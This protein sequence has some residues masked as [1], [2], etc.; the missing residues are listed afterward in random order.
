ML[1][2]HQQWES[3]LFYILTNIWCQQI[4]DVGRSHRCVVVSRCFNLGFPD[5]TDVEHLFICLFPIPISC[6]V[7]HLLRPLAHF[8]TRLFFLLNFRSSLRILDNNSSSVVWFAK[9]FF[10]SVASLFSLW[11]TLHGQCFCSVFFKTYLIWILFYSN[12][13]EK[14]WY[15]K[16]V[17]SVG[18]STGCTLESLGVFLK[19]YISR[20]GPCLR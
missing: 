14:Q 12:K 8:L 9:I 18:L 16:G 20:P 15:T 17:K 5:D 1:Q 13:F 3:P 11:L 4:S 2:S 7:W 6:L 19:I 10:Q